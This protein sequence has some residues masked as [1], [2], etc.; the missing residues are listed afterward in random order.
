MKS[1]KNETSFYPAFVIVV[2]AYDLYEQ[3]IAGYVIDVSH[4]LIITV[5]IN[6]LQSQ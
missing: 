3:N 4:I 6:G 1:G 2:A 5:S